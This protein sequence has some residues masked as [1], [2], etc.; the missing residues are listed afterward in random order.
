M[1]IKT[2]LTLGQADQIQSMKRYIAWGFLCYVVA[3]TVVGVGVN[4]IF[5]NADPHSM[6]TAITVATIWTAAA[7]A[8][9]IFNRRNKRPMFFQ[10][11][12]RLLWGFMW[13]TSMFQFVIAFLAILATFSINLRDPGMIAA[14]FTGMGF[15]LLLNA[16]AVWL[17]VRSSVVMYWKKHQQLI[18]KA[19]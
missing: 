12:R 3:L 17:F 2:R 10:E 8:C 18:K 9:E 11:Y 5:P 1:K 13:T 7:V 16:F 14:I 19:G 4:F 6:T 15:G